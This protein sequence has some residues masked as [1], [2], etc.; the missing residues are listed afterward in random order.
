MLVLELG[1]GYNRLDTMKG[2]GGNMQ[3]LRGGS[4]S[5]VQDQSTFCPLPLIPHKPS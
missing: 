4:P 3:E 1:E 2:R 5:L